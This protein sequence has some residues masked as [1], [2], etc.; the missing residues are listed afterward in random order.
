LPAGAIVSICFSARGNVPEALPLVYLGIH[1]LAEI[2]NIRV[3]SAA[4]D[5]NALART[6][7]RLGP[8]FD[9]VF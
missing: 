8:Q 9:I 2:N 7:L 4:N 6:E 5:L 1:A 3:I